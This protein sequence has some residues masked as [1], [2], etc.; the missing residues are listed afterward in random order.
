MKKIE[1]QIRLN[2]ITPV[3]AS[4]EL[5]Q[6]EKLKQ[7]EKLHEHESEEEMFE[8]SQSDLDSDESMLTNDLLL[9]IKNYFKKV[10][11]V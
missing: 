4:K 2:R 11:K 5:K 6:I 3:N 9:E 10:N 8:A 1:A 7:M